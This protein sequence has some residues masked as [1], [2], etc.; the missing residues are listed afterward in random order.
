MPGR[1]AEVTGVAFL[2]DGKTV[3]SAHGNAG[4]QLHETASGKKLADLSVPGLGVL[5]VAVA[6]DG[7]TLA[8]GG[9]D[10]VVR[11]WDAQ[12][13]KE[14]KALAGHQASAAA[15][16]FSADGKTLA[17]GG[18][19]GTIRLWDLPDGKA[20]KS[21][22]AKTNRVTALTFSA[23]GKTLASA[24]ASIKPLGGLAM[25]AADN[26]RLWNVKEGKEIATLA[27]TGSTVALGPDAQLVAVAGYHLDIGGPMDQGP[28]RINQMTIMP[29]LRVTL[30]DRITGRELLRL[31][32]AGGTVALTPDGRFLL[33]GRGTELHT[34][35]LSG[36]QFGNGGF[37]VQGVTLWETQT[38]LAIQKVAL[39][40]SSP[41]VLAVSPD[42]THLAAGSHD[43]RV[44]LASLTPANW[45]ADQA[46][47]A[48]AKELDQA[49]ADLA[50]E[51]VKAYR[52]I[53]T[54]SAAAQRGV[55][56][57]GEKLAPVKVDVPRI[58]KLVA[59]LDVRR[60]AVREAAL[61]E[62]RQMGYDAE[63]ELRRVRKEK[64]SLEVSK[65]VEELLAALDH[66]N[67]P[68][69]ALRPLRAV[70]ILERIRTPESR[71]ILERLVKGEPEARLTR[72]AAM[73]LERLR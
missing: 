7:K 26:A 71:Q 29:A 47:Q 37:P 25:A 44:H 68:P 27:A 33:T 11:L 45:K 5:A 3:V 61:Q 48:G 43:G 64:L 63:P 24:G 28:I 46:K 20:R 38:G 30:V 14:L 31:N 69:E 15:L 4:L 6:P 17:S 23:D 1:S 10:N 22:G 13:R 50:G 2:P 65:R 36:I 32:D 57:L 73:A 54:L 72:E 8:T 40:D 58:R 39:P 55:T 49:W 60:F 66:R 9:F 56:M 16:A 19:D 51:P 21:W 12:T 42:G 53:W 59:D 34:Q 18:Y 62:L 41:T 52:G 35:G 67:P 70:L